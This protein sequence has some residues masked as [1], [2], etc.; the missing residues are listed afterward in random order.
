[1]NNSTYITFCRRQIEDFEKGD[2]TALPFLY[3]C[4]AGRDEKL[5]QKAAELLMNY[6]FRLRPY[7]VIRF[8]RKMKE[9]TSMEW[10]AAW[11]NFS[12]EFIRYLLT[13]EEWFVVLAI[14]TFHPNGYYRE[15]CLRYLCL[16]EGKALP[17]FL[18]SMNDYVKKIST[19][20][21][22]STC[23]IV[24]KCSAKEL[25]AVLPYLYQLKQGRRKTTQEYEIIVNTITNNIFCSSELIEEK[26][27]IGLDKKARRVYYELLLKSKKRSLE[28]L[29]NCL[30]REKEPFNRYLL[31]QKM[32]EEKFEDK[33]ELF[34]FLL[35]HKDRRLRYLVLQKLY[36]LQGKEWKGFFDYL[37]DESQGI[38]ELARF[39]IGK[40]MD[41]DFAQFYRDELQNGNVKSALLGLS[42]TGTKEDSVLIRPFLQ[43]ENLKI[44][45]TALIALSRIWG[46]AEA[47][48]YYSFLIDEKKGASKIA[49]R[50]I[51]KYNIHYGCTQYYNDI[52]KTESIV[53][54]KRLCTLICQAECWDKLPYLIL[55]CYDSKAELLKYHS[56][57]LR[58]YQHCYTK[59]TKNQRKK[60]EEVLQKYQQK[61]PK[62]VIKNIRFLMPEE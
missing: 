40:T 41:F 53:L 9:Y 31:A 60:I 32:L 48:L 43:N 59:P 15:K 38:R 57:D 24:K 42:E 19:L 5:I 23:E 20:A 11:Q 36:I 14:G 35:K 28:T 34:Y 33:E 37:I 58:D 2:F 4:F 54:K 16:F 55:L 30:K 21:F 44:V 49:F 17:F 56:L 7:E 1:M 47:S 45:K 8:G 6:F 22:E 46:E 51:Q 18:L 3:S 61:I 25:L 52:L 39:A 26:D 50:I 10:Y 62:D 12:P 27:S 29:M 13:E